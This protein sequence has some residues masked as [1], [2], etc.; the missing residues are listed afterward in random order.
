MTAEELAYLA[1]LA[2]LAARYFASTDPSNARRFADAA[3]AA[4]KLGAD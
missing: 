3:L 1:E 2:A 4:V